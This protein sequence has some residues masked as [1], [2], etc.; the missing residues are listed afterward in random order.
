[1]WIRSWLPSPLQ[2]IQQFLIAFRIENSLWPMRPCI[3]RPF[4]F[5]PQDLPP[6]LLGGPVF[7]W[8]SLPL[9][10]HF[11]RIIILHFVSCAFWSLFWPLPG[12]RA[13]SSRSWRFSNARAHHSNL[14]LKAVW[15]FIQSLIYSTNNHWGPTVCPSWGIRWWA[16]QKQPPSKQ[17]DRWWPNFTNKYKW[18]LW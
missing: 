13:Q 11:Y 6:T 7:S 4:P 3:K 10:S 15:P 12:L 18:Q 5:I 2:L 1:M 9:T 16:K 8:S 17:K 14:I